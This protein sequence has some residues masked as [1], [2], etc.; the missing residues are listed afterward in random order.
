MSERVLVTGGAGF[1]GSHTVDRLLESG[2]EVRIVDNL[3]PQV[4]PGGVRPAHLAPEAELITA[5]VRDLDAMRAAVRG[6]TRVIHYVAETSVGQSMYQCDHHIDVNVRG[7]AV[8]FRALREEGVVPQRLV[9]S[10]SRAVYGEGAQRCDRHGT[11][12][13]G[14]RRLDDLEAGTWAH[15]CPTCGLPVEAEADPMAQGVNRRRI[16]EDDTNIAL[17]LKTYDLGHRKLPPE[18]RDVAAY[19]SLPLRRK[20]TSLNKFYIL[21]EWATWVH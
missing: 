16:D 9:V 8:L 18:R 13:P 21:P 12:H 3:H 1:I 7:T 4:H 5:D 10:S 19:L 15:R 11:L 14:P 2:A 17:H 6:V 20:I